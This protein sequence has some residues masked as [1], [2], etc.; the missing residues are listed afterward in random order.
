MGLSFKGTSILLNG[1]MIS[2]ESSLFVQLRDNNAIL[3]TMKR[4]HKGREATFFLKENMPFSRYS[5]GREPYVSCSSLL[6]FVP[7]DCSNDWV[8]VLSQVCFPN[9]KVL[10]LAC[11]SVLSSSFLVNA[12]LPFLS[13]EPMFSYNNF[14]SLQRIIIK[15]ED[16]RG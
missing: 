12:Y 7:Q 15:C 6:L 1:K 8:E 13:L 9:M 3:V 2:P 16:L 10:T 4:L 5:L 14:P 11:W